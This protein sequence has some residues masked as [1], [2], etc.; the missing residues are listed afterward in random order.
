MKV[1]LHQQ[2]RAAELL[3]CVK[4]SLL[5]SLPSAYPT[6]IMPTVKDKKIRLTAIMC[7][8]LSN[9]QREKVKKRL[10]KYPQSSCLSELVVCTRGLI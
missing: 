3:M 6:Q 7:N 1:F 9:A 8:P 10:R 4:I 5:H 2:L